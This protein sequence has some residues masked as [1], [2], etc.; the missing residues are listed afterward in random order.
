M[1]R[2]FEISVRI[3]EGL[4]GSLSTSDCHKVGIW[5]GCGPQCWVYQEGRCE[6]ADEIEELDGDE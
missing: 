3:E 6:V 5:G 2:D 1:D 4:F